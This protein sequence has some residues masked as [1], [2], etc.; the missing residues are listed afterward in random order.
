MEMIVQVERLAKTFRTGWGRPPVRALDS[1]SL[2]VASGEVFGL[3]GPNGAGKTTL[4][5][6]LL[7]IC[8][9][10]A[11][12][13]RVLDRP[14][15][16]V[17]TRARIGYLP[18][19]HRY[20]LHLTG[21]GVVRWFARLSGVPSP[22]IEPRVRRLLERVGM[23]RWAS[24]RLRKYS[25]GMVQRLG[26]AV[27]LVHSPDLLFLDEP[28]D[29]VDPVG[30]REIRNILLEERQR[31]ATIFI[32]SHLLS[33]IER[34][35]DRVAILSHGRVL[36]TGSIAELTERGQAYRISAGAVPSPVLESIRPHVASLESSD[37]WIRV[38]VRGLE[39]LNQALDRLRASGCLLREVTPEKETLEESFIRILDGEEARP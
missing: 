35:C 28:T 23:E 9:P 36:R 1:V 39:E 21:S 7:G 16:D 4:V 5:K 11:G 15:G 25:K 24:V 27:A 29:G 30:R 3:L 18:E 2:S 31:G 32:N 22:E 12:S 14:A 37:G 38:R 20:P 33:E 8:R 17:P 13:A 19:G 34:T 10:D 6:L 26:L